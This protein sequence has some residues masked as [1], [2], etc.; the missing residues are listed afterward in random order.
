M[1]ALAD[2]A[3]AMHV[4]YFEVILSLGISFGV[5]HNKA[6]FFGNDN[7]VE[8]LKVANLIEENDNLDFGFPPCD[9]LQDVKDEVVLL[10][11]R[12]NVLV[13]VCDSL[14]AHILYF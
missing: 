4:V 3:L 12:G 5:I 6:I 10:T 13:V 9:F 8:F 11:V 1:L 2:P 14:E 7:F